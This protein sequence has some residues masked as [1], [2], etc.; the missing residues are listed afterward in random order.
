MKQRALPRHTA[1]MLSIILVGLLGFFLV[2]HL[3]PSL[4]AAWGWAPGMVLLALL[5]YAGA[6]ATRVR[7]IAMQERIAKR[8]GVCAA[9]GYALR[10]IEPEGD[11]CRVCPECGSAWKLDA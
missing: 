8:R 11:D 9:C 6:L 1:P 2:R 3:R 10:E 4:P 5:I 7:E